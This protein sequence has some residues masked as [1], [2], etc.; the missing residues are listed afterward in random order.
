MGIRIKT[1]P[2]STASPHVAGGRWSAGVRSVLLVASI[3]CGRGRDRFGRRSSRVADNA[4]R[5]VYTL[6][7][8]CTTRVGRVASRNLRSGKPKFDLPTPDCR[9]PLDASVEHCFNHPYV[10]NPCLHFGYIEM[11]HEI[12][13]KHAISIIMAAL[14]F[15]SLGTPG[16]FNGFRVFGSVTARQSSSGRQPNC[17]VEQR[18]PPIFGRA[19]ITLGIRPHSRYF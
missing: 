8:G 2:A 10:K 9:R 4:V 19:A 1:A 17:C 12:E 15:V 16:N 13:L 3:D 6:R 18:A 11:R 14:S 7:P 5:I